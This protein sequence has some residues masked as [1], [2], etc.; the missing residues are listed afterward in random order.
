MKNLDKYILIHNTEEGDSFI[1]NSITRSSVILPKSLNIK[2]IEDIENISD[3]EILNMLKENLIILDDTIDYL[4][5]GRYVSN[6]SK[7]YN[8]VLTITDA[9]TFNCNLRCA[10]CMEQNRGNVFDVKYMNIDER[11]NI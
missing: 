2:N 7:Y 9:V 11:I 1:Y 4:R 10:Y 5:L 6:K 3:E 8:R